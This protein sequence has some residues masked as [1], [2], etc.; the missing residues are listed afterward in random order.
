MEELIV[1]DLKLKYPTSVP[2]PRGSAWVLVNGRGDNDDPNVATWKAFLKQIEA[3]AKTI[4]DFP[5]AP[6][7]RK[8]PPEQE[9]ALGRPLEP[10]VNHRYV[11]VVVAKAATLPLAERAVHDVLI[12]ATSQ[13]WADS[14]N[15]GTTAGVIKLIAQTE[16]VLKLLTIFSLGVALVAVVN[17]LVVEWLRAERKLPEWG[18][19][20][21]IGMTGTQ[22]S[23]LATLEGATL[24][25]LGTGSGIGLSIAIGRA[26]SRALTPE[27]RATSPSD[28]PSHPAS[29]PSRSSPPSRS[30]PGDLV[31]ESACP[32]LPAERIPAD[33]LERISSECAS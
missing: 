26:I 30:A 19:L 27:T 25:A 5:P 3:K 14:L 31:G 6:D 28:S 20:K 12:R 2:I 7:F 17:L 29:A 32:L 22:L 13:D 15:G 8:S 11:A 4:P 21:A 23:V 24:G 33:A 9:S 16:Q 10:I 18:M 1:D